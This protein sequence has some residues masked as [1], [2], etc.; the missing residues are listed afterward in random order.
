M[1][2]RYLDTVV[3]DCAEQG[4][5][6]EVVKLLSILVRNDAFQGHLGLV[7]DSVAILVDDYGD[8]EMFCVHSPAVDE[9][10]VK[11]PGHFRK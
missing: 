8:I 4:G 6:V 10:I 7:L 5:Y 9:E 11:S 3:F 2:A 1:V